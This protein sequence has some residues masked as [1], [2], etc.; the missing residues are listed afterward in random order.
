MFEGF[1]VAQTTGVT[2]TVNGSVTKVL[3][4]SVTFTDQGLDSDFKL[5]AF[6][7]ITNGRTTLFNTTVYGNV[8]GLDVD[9]NGGN[10]GHYTGPSFQGARDLPF[11][12]LVTTS[13]LQ[14]PEPN[15]IVLAGIAA[16]GGFWLRSPSL[17][18]EAGYRHFQK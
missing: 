2:G 3:L 1:T 6:S 12:L 14:L 9:D 10:I 5:T 8:V 15:T 4:G 17:R 16:I 18:R 13:P 11:S 7:S